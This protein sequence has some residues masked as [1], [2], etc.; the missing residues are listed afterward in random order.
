VSD[1][2]YRTGFYALGADTIAVPASV[3][4]GDLMVVVLT[5]SGTTSGPSVSSGGG[6]WTL[7]RTL[8]ASGSATQLTFTRFATALDPNSTIAVASGVANSNY[9]KAFAAWSGVA[10]LSTSAG[11]SN[12]GGGP[13]TPRAISNPTQTFT[14]RVM[15][16]YL[17]SVVAAGNPVTISHDAAT[18]RI[19]SA[20]SGSTLVQA[21]TEDAHTTSSPTVAR[22]ATG[23]GSGGGAY[24]TLT[25]QLLLVPSNTAPG[26]PGTPTVTPTTVGTT[27]QPTGTIAYSAASD[28]DNQT[29]QYEVDFSADNGAT[30]SNILAPSASLSRVVDFSAAPPTTAARVRVRSWDGV[31]YGPWSASSALF[32]VSHNVAPNAPSS[33]L[34]SGTTVERLNAQRL[35]WAFS[36]PN[37]GD[38]QSQFDLQWRL[39]S[40]S[41]NS[42][43]QTTPNQYYDAPSSTFP[44]GSIEWQVR[45]YDA[46]GVVG[47]WSA[48]AF[49]TSATT[50]GLPTI[51]APTNGSTL[52]TSDSLAAWSV[53]GQDSYQVR[54]VKDSGGSP[55]TATVYYDSG[56]VVSTTARNAALTFE[57][58]NRFEH[59]QV[60][61][62]VTSLWSSWASVRVQVS[63]TPPLNP[64]LVAIAMDG[65]AAIQVS[66]TNPLGNLLTQNQASL[67]TDTAGW[68]AAANCGMSRSTAQAL[69]GS[70]S[71]A[72]TS[73]A[74]G[75]MTA[76]T[77]NPLPAVTPG[78]VYTAT[79]SFRA[80]TV[81]RAIAIRID[82]YTAA[83][84]YISTSYGSTGADNT[85][86]WQSVTTTG[87]APVGATQA[88]L[89]VTV[90]GTGAASEV[91]YVDAVGLF[92]N[93]TGN[94]VPN[95]DFENG[96]AGTTTGA[97]APA[98]SA[99]TARA[100]TGRGC[101][102]ST[103]PTASTSGSFFVV[104][105][106]A[107]SMTAGFT[108]TA[109]AWVYVP[110]G[111]PSPRITIAGAAGS[112][113]EATTTTRDAWAQI[114]TTWTCSA[115]GSY[116]VRIYNNA[117]VTAGQTVYVDA[118]QVVV[119]STAQPWLPPRTSN[120]IPNPSFEDGGTGSFFP[121]DEGGSTVSSYTVPTVPDAFAGS[122]VLRIVPTGSGG[123]AQSISNFDVEPGG[124]YTFS[125]YVRGP[126]QGT[127]EVVAY[128]FDGSGNIVGTAASGVTPSSS[129]QRISATFTV[130][131]TGR[132]VQLRLTVAGGYQSGGVYE[133]DAMQ[134]ERGSIATP[135]VDGSL[136]NGYSWE[137][138]ENLIA[139]GSFETDL[140]GWQGLN[141]NLLTAN[142]SSLE[143]TTPA[144]SVY[145]CS[146]TRV[147]TQSLTG[148]ASMSLT[149][150]AA[151]DMGTYVDSNRAVGGAQAVIPGQV[152]TAVASFRAATVGRAVRV[153]I[154]WFSGAAGNNFIA[155]TIGTNS[156]DNTAGWQ[157]A[158]V[159]G[160]AP[161][162]A[163]YADLQLIVVGT[164][165]S[166]EVHYI[167]AIG[168]FEDPL[169]NLFPYPD[170]EAGSAAWSP[171][172]TTVTTPTGTTYTGM[173]SM[174][175]SYSGASATGKGV[176]VDLAG[177]VVGQ[178]YTATAMVRQGATMTIAQLTITGVT[179]TVITT[180]VISNTTWSQALVTFTATATSHTMTIKNV[181]AHASFSFY[182]DAVQVVA[183]TTAP[184]WLPPHTENLV[185][186]PSAEVD[187]FSN[188][189]LIAASGGSLT[190][191]TSDKY[192]GSASY[193]LT[194]GTG[195]YSH[196]YFACAEQ[197]P[198]T[199]QS[200][201]VSAWIKPSTGGNILIGLRQSHTFLQAAVA[202]T[203]GV[204]QRVSATFV[205]VAGSIAFGANIGYENAGPMPAA[206][207]TI[208]IDAVQVE[209]GSVATPYVDGS[210]GAGYQWESS[211]NLLLTEQSSFE[212]GTAPWNVNSGSV[213]NS[214]AQAFAGTKSLLWTNGASVASGELVYSDFPTTPAAGSILTLSMYVRPTA[215]RSL[216]AEFY[217]QGG[218]GAAGTADVSCPANTWTRL[219]VTAV[220]PAGTTV[221]YATLASATGV[222]AGT[223]IYIDAVQVEQ[224]DHATAYG[225]TGAANASTSR[226]QRPWVLGGSSLE[227]LNRITSAAASGTYGLDP[228]IPAY[229]NNGIPNLGGA[230]T[231]VA[232]APNT[233][234]TLSYA[235]QGG[236]I[237]RV[238]DGATQ[239]ALGSA[240]GVITST[241]TSVTFTT[242]PATTQ[243]RLQF[244]WNGGAGASAAAGGAFYLD[245]VQLEQKDHA[246]P[247]GSTGGANATTSRR[248]FPWA[249]P[250]APVASN[251]IWRREKTKGGAGIRRAKN[252]GSNTSW[253]DYTVSNRKEYEYQAV[254]V[255]SNG[256]AAA[257]AWTG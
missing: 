107:V 84:G 42:V 206:G 199:G 236:A 40:G 99:S 47:P 9:V 125:A 96:I 8:L 110:T 249:I 129:W 86:G 152:Y 204:W 61:V 209:A 161:A 220:V 225:A 244:T 154:R 229:L 158:T 21:I 188:V 136:G 248:Q 122:R 247:Y 142:D 219:V 90:S 195:A 10:S 214:S 101:L 151:G 81:G 184:T 1:V 71:L 245:A 104:G 95:P 22:T 148:T 226:R 171:V 119:G 134:L 60:R 231:V 20:A 113:P 116:D 227:T 243:V 29:L 69:N 50:P 108:Y 58:N 31:A 176:S 141:R 51:T 87:Q 252:L 200:Y 190:R 19:N 4:V 126:A 156:A 146:T 164:G 246:T 82:W 34:P 133:F 83:T 74:A 72:L 49:F 77:G 177:L 78:Q 85:A 211:E 196:A 63:F 208:Y 117:A 241:R 66:V 202:V 138:S 178:T 14:G 198:V 73:T 174:L 162:N 80:A 43:T 105:A 32:T 140:T 255:G 65:A 201:T 64:T 27:G 222:A 165:G 128:P 38:S 183:G 221:A 124:V 256:T 91:H 120:L 48:S 181:V 16:I 109:S 53:P 15:P 115:S 218:G 192:I 173:K 233:T 6:S 13:S 242:G 52:A 234:Y 193:L 169:G 187:A 150:G 103:W 147:T 139:N 75:D 240:S 11:A 67:E 155:S 106:S 251:E 168:L 145:N 212:G 160:Q 216:H 166:A 157:Q 163:T 2:T 76:G 93:P 254:A 179:P 194:V 143:S 3:Q 55:D 238:L 5:V 112:N 207:S 203:A 39:G 186:N 215:T 131:S 144:W 97:T 18:S 149:S 7:E 132:L 180:P 170:F 30:W 239:L 33:L 235:M 26:A 189:T 185:V 237:S 224:K 114:W 217:F 197:P 24:A 70:A 37:A 92:L 121:Y 228:A 68:F 23:T 111:S 213:A 46:Q 17:S 44:A 28:V 191:S 159:T 167:D 88:Q 257:S 94:L 12:G 205:A 98:L 123:K 54:R 250:P 137:A 223:T 62:K 230:E 35:S 79:A 41:W 153:E 59:V 135:Y 25:E 172:G 182:V 56:E 253:T 118:V 57:T 127:C 130:P 100:Y 36:D 102:L 89:V 175:V 232:V 210:L 45:T